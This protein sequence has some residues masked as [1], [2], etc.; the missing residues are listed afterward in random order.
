MFMN[1]VFDSKLDN[2]ELNKD[3]IKPVVEAKWYI[4][5]VYSGFEASVVAEIRQKLY[6][7]P[8]EAQMH[9]IVIPIKE[10]V[11][12][13]RGKKVTIKKNFLPGYVLINMQLTEDLV[14]LIRS[15]AK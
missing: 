1:Y 7:K 11:K 15:V 12:V 5:Q 8:L 2:N 4:L 6:N 13:K 9:D 3:K 10:V 14:S